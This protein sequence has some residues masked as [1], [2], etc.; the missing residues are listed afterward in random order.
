[1]KN[2]NTINSLNQNSKKESE[3]NKTRSR[4]K[5][6]KYKFYLKEE[7]TGNELSNSDAVFEELKDLANADQESL[8]VIY[9]NT[10]N[11]VI[12]KDMVSLGGIDWAGVDMRILFRRIILN[13]A[14]AFFIV[15]NHPTGDPEPSNADK[16]LTEQISKASELLQLRFLDHVIIGTDRHYSFNRN[17]D[18]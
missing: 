10:K 7:A 12:G 11:K 15:H 17:G 8:W 9:V 2:Q 3:A 1:M 4:I 16:E 5:S 13:N 14:P 18:L 6:T